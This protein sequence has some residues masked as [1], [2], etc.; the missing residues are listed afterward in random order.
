[1]AEYTKDQAIEILKRHNAYQENMKDHGA[2]ILS[3]IAAG[4]AKADAEREKNRTLDKM[5]KELGALVAM[6]EEIVIDETDHIDAI[7]EDGRIGSAGTFT[8][9]ILD[10]GKDVFLTRTILDRQRRWES[11]NGIAKVDPVA[12][13]DGEIAE[14]IKKGFS[15]VADIYKFRDRVH[16]LHLTWGG[17]GKTISRPVGGKREF[18]DNITIT[19]KKKNGTTVS[20]TMPRYVESWSLGSRTETGK[21]DMVA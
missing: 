6:V 8:R 5:G 4:Y 1:M 15:K 9:D 13:H 2:S 10:L 3:M 20:E 16:K 21:D 18:G 14:R 7:I 17:S 19:R 11:Q 12:K